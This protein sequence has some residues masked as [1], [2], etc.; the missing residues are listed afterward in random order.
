MFKS[1]KKSSKAQKKHLKKS[2]SNFEVH[3][4]VCTVY[5]LWFDNNLH[6]KPNLQSSVDASLK[7]ERSEVFLSKLQNLVGERV[8]PTLLRDWACARYVKLLND[9]LPHFFFLFL[10]FFGG[11]GGGGGARER[12]G[13][14]PIVLRSSSDGS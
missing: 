6:P 10:L 12:S 2:D 11:G 1:C 4:V 13:D 14:D 8:S 5:H 7:S 9:T 3:N